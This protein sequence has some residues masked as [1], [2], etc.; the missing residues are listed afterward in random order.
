M[1][2]VFADVDSDSELLRNS[3]T[4]IHG[5]LITSEYFDEFPPDY[6][7]CA[8]KYASKMGKILRK[9]DVDIIHSHDWM[10][11]PAG[12]MAKKLINK[13]LITHVHATE[14]DRTGGHYPNPFV[15]QIEKKGF[16]LADRVISVSEF[17][18][19]ILIN[20]YSVNRAKIDVVHNGV[21]E[22]SKKK[23][24]PALRALKDLGYKIV[25]FLGRITLQKGPEY[26]I[27]SAKR[28]LDINP[29]VVFLVV[30]SGD[31]QNAMMGEAAS[32][33]ILDKVLFTGFLRDEEKD[34]IYQTADLYVVPSV[35][36][37]FGI[38]PLEAI[39]NHTPVLISKQ[40]GA[41]EV[42]NHVLKVLSFISFFVLKYSI[43]S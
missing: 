40:S 14:I 22:V 34:R 5:N 25:L 15:Y 3:Y 29:K 2:L 6:I 24:P 26:F 35:S 18:K 41:T 13:P 32:L 16:E 21:D 10:T 23:F 20:N 9:C 4:S 43:K 1:D 37:P 42:L 28:V 31:M 36:E 19:N 33:G 27:R 39:A 12:I 17:T 7:N 11:Y 38:T 8:L 30:G